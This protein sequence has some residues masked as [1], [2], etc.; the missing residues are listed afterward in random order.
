MVEKVVGGPTLESLDEAR[1]K[2]KAEEIRER[3]GAK[4]EQE[5]QHE[6]ER[7]EADKSIVTGL[8]LY[9]ASLDRA[10]EA[11]HRANPEDHNLSRYDELLRQIRVA[12]SLFTRDVEAITE[13]PSF[14][15]LETLDVQM[16]ELERIAGEI[17]KLDA[18]TPAWNDERWRD[19]HTRERFTAREQEL[20]KRFGCEAS[21]IAYAE[22]QLKPETK[23]YS[24]P[25]TKGLIA[26]LENVEHVFFDPSP[27][28][29]RR[30]SVRI[31]EQKSFKE[32]QTM[33][34]RRQIELRFEPPVFHAKTYDIRVIRLERAHLTPPET[35]QAAG[36]VKHA[37]TIAKKLGLRICTDVEALTL[38]SHL[39]EQG[40]ARD[41]AI[42]VQRDLKSRLF[43]SQR[44]MWLSYLGLEIS[45]Y[46]AGSNERYWWFVIPKE[47]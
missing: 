20:C 32:F 1:L 46:E 26:K 28:E 43:D 37:E 34:L 25:L 29:V 10:F 9:L 40:V 11:F 42:P 38:E 8:P 23:V 12:T 31:G 7:L 24:G 27:E 39:L 6:R 16:Q 21:Q 2:E 33:F 41:T 35:E 3:I 17:H 15:Q 14:A 22:W 47:E 18:H 30:D 44:I 4:D 19:P 45:G 13:Q 5:Q 36:G